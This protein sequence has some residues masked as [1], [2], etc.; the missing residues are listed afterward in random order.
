M[1]YLLSTLITICLS[2]FVMGQNDIKTILSS[3]NN[4]KNM[5]QEAEDYFRTKHP[6]LRAKDLVN[7]EHRD[8][9]FVKYMRWKNYWENS[10]NP[11]GTLGD[12]TSYYLNNEYIQDDLYSDIEWNNISNTK[13][14]TTQISMGRTS[15][16][17]FHPTDPNIFYVGASIGGIWKTEDGGQTYLPLGDDL[18]FLA[19][20]SIV[21]DQENPETIY[22]AIGDHVWFGLPSIGVYKSTDGGQTWKSTSLNFPTSQNRRIY[23]LTADPNQPSTLLAA[24]DNGL[25]RTTD[26]FDSFEQ[27][28]NQTCVQVHYKHGDSNTVYLA[29]NNGRFFK[30]VDGANSFNL[31]EDFGNNSITIALTRQN[32]NKVVITHG[33]SLRVSMDSGQSFTETQALPENRTNQ[34]LSISPQN[35]ND[36]IAGYFDLFRSTDGGANFSQ[37]SHWLGN[38]GLPVV[39]V[40][41]RNT[42]INPLQND[43]VYFCHDGGIDA[44]NVE[45]GEFIYLSDGLIITQFYD[46]AVSQ[47]NEHVVSGGSQDNGSMY[48]N[49]NKEWDD[50]APT[51]D[52][53]ITEI[54]PTNENIIYWEYQ[55]GSMHRF[56]GTNNKNI[57]PPNEN[58]EGAWITPFRLDPNNPQRIIAGYRNVY[59]SLDQGNSWTDISGQLANGQKLNHVAISET[60][61]ERIYAIQGS[62]LFVKDINSDIWNTKSLPSGGITDL[63]VN[64]H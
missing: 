39:H 60:N 52:G 25:Y 17:A 32:P 37:I 26:G 50:L 40:D 35:E 21:L 41:M 49:A 4:F 43:R 29:T 57:S 51:G 31:I 48:R 13:F 16:M 63:E 22:I 6:N 1:K 23:W 62:N 58:G 34:Y 19:V 14:I 15:S 46:I 44:F 36:Y 28:T 11:D 12:F 8:G 64:S 27:L 3:G 33:T 42:F 61:G 2:Y 20:S 9:E 5:C 24:T 45:T 38:N 54:D 30:S 10:L 18:P 47:S 53:M 55:F 59:E 56:N 7:G